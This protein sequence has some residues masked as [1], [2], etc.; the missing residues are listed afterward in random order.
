M[1]LLY[2]CA[3][4]CNVI[5]V[6]ARELA[7]RKYPPA[8]SRR[9]RIRETAWALTR[10]DTERC[11]EGPFACGDRKSRVDEGKRGWVFCGGV[12]AASAPRVPNWNNRHRWLFMLLTDQVEPTVGKARVLERG[13]LRGWGLIRA[14]RVTPNQHEN[15][16][17]IKKRGRLLREKT[18]GTA[19]HRVG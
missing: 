6:C 14:A 15:L 3:R 2:R 12:G 18:A 17:G 4:E 16:G 9:V 10:G 5:A 13:C 1:P 8:A 7:A 19:E 11:G